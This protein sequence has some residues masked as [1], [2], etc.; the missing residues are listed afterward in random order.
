MEEYKHPLLTS[1]TRLVL[2]VKVGI[3]DYPL[4]KPVWK[5]QYNK[6]YET[7]LSAYGLMIICNRKQGHYNDRGICEMMTL[8]KIRYN[9]AKLSFLFSSWNRF[10]KFSYDEH[11]EHAIAY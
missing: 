2:L 9:P 8:N 10:E 4:P 5:R 7:N 1:H 3:R 6:G 11:A